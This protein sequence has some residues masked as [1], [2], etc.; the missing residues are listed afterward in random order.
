[1][2]VF[3]KLTPFALFYTVR[4]TWRVQQGPS[5]QVS[6]VYTGDSA[7]PC[8]QTF[9]RI[10]HRDEAQTQQLAGTTC[11]AVFLVLCN[12]QKLCSNHKASDSSLSGAM[13]LGRR[14]SGVVN[15]L[16]EHARLHGCLK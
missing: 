16:M 10:V 12:G 3:G 13:H 7:Q 8:E 1:M 9:S 11:K 2:T 15:G 6:S 14:S 5:R 4:V